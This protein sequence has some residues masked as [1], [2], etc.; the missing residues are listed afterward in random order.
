MLHRCILVILL[1]PGLLTPVFSS[2]LEILQEN[3][4]QCHS[5]AKRKGGLLIDSRESLIK[6]GD[7]GEAIIPGE[8]KNSYLIETLFPDAESHMPPKEQ[9]EPR[10]I[11]ALE[12]WI[13]EGAK[14]D[15]SEWDQLTKPGKTE[16]TLSSFPDL[17]SPVLAMA[18][19]PSATEL[20]TGRG[21][22][23]ELYGVSETKDKNKPVELKYQKA[24]EG[25]RD[26]IQSLAF[27]PDGKW[28]V[29][30][31]FRKVI[32]HPL[33]GDGTPVTITDPF[34][35]RIT[36][37]QFTEDGKNVIVAD[38]LPSQRSSLHIIDSEKKKVT[39]SAEGI[40]DD[41]I[42]DISVSGNRLIT[43]SADK[44][45][46]VR[47]I[48]SLKP[49]TT[50]EG[51]TSYVLGACFSPDG[52]QIATAGD[53]EAIKV[54]DS[55][56]G[57]QI[58]S[59]STRKSGPVG[60]IFWGTDPDN[61]AKKQKE[62]DQEKAE[63]I[64]TDRIVTINDLGQPGTFTELKMHEGGE[65]STGARERRHTGVSAALTSMACDSEKWILY[66]G[67][68]D[69]RIFAWDQAGKKILEF[70]RA[71]ELTKADQ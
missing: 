50:L 69:G 28:L 66:A 5:A 60:G 70:S 27:S 14:W 54:W 35:G 24:F 67:S 40:H 6:G 20:A 7:S 62:K 46:I 23:I 22:Q 12:K 68:E 25:H 2:P 33:S 43:A 3:C 52:E 56:T 1:L 39:R 37:L 51:H 59:F 64:N 34:L 71:I 38:S 19:S 45:A 10:Q 57:T 16:V 9:L 63:A 47:D 36:A 41:A 32:L 11:A 42:Y 58:V 29:S 15:Q 8:S 48:K 4:V 65:R 55:G 53:D 21:N 17:Y 49:V 26:Q 31:G 30:G 61:L 13:D 18:L 44:L